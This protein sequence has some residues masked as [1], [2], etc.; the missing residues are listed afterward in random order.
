MAKCDEGYLCA[1]CGREVK[2]LIDSSLYLQYVIGWIGP[3][4]LHRT[5]DVHLRCNPSLAQFIDS[6]DFQP[7]ILCEGQFDRRVLDVESAAERTQLV[8]QGYRRLREL[9]RNRSIPIQQ[10]PISRQEGG[11]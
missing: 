4:A 7:P 9:Q 6:S 3:E 8:T 10:Y 2:R 1:V 5:P 11:L